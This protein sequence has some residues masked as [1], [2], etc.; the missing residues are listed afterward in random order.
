MKQNLVQNAFFMKNK[1]IIANSWSNGFNYSEKDYFFFSTIQ[2]LFSL[3]SF[4]EEFFE[5]FDITPEVF[6]VTVKTISSRFLSPYPLKTTVAV[7]NKRL[8]N[9][10]RHL[11]SFYSRL[12]S[13]ILYSPRAKYYLLIKLEA[14][15]ELF[16]R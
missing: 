13:E 2:F 8:Q 12:K 9:F 1:S 15:V 5:V 3:W 16:I 14:K 11:K 6:D 7:K 10:Q 4:P